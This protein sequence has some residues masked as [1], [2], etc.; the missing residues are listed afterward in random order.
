MLEMKDLSLAPQSGHVSNLRGPTGPVIPRPW[1]GIGTTVVA[2]GSRDAI[3]ASKSA[4]AFFTR[5]DAIKARQGT[6]SCSILVVYLK[7]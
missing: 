6:V 1:L 3:R 7:R 5:F 2:T 4:P